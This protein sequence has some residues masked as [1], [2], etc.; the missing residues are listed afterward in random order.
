MD[1]QN[2][3]TKTLLMCSK[4]KTAKCLRMYLTPT[5]YWDIRACYHCYAFKP[6][7]EFEGL[8]G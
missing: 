5:L 2:N 1:M 3:F 7:G 4:H 6:T 8:L